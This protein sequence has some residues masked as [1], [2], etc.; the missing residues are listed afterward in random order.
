MYILYSD[1]AT[2]FDKFGSA[3]QGLGIYRQCFMVSFSKDIGQG[4]CSPVGCKL[5]SLLQIRAQGYHIG[6]F[7][8]A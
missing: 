3:V 7:R 2:C 6:A 5:S 4:L 1:L 8:T